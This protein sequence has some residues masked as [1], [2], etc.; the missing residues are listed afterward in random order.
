MTNTTP[1]FIECEKMHVT[2]P[3]SDLSAAIEFYVTSLG[4]SW[5]LSGAS[6]DVCGDHVGEDGDF[7]EG[8]YA[9]P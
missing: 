7:F 2:L 5:D 4:F 3:V 8:D 1:P 6:R 9:G